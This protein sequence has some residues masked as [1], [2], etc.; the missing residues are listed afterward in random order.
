MRKQLRIRK[1][2]WGGACVGTVVVCRKEEAVMLVVYI[3]KDQNDATIREI[4]RPVA[5]LADLDWPGLVRGCAHQCQSPFIPVGRSAGKVVRGAY[6][7]RVFSGGSS[8]NSG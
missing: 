4:L 3:R 7:G 5:G 6:E 1:A 2:H 8:A